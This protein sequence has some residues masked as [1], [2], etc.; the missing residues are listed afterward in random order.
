MYW[1]TIKIILIQYD[2]IAIILLVQKTVVWFLIKNKKLK[3]KRSLSF[4]IKILYL[5]IKFSTFLK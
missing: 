4:I 5:K 2:S 3:I 1:K